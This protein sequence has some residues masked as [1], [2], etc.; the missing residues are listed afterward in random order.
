MRLLRIVLLALMW[1]APA[2]ARDT[3]V[4]EG[5]RL[6]KSQLSVGESRWKLTIRRNADGDSL[7]VEA[8]G[9]NWRMAHEIRRR[10]IVDARFVTGFLTTKDGAVAIL[11][12]KWDNQTCATSHIVIYMPLAYVDFVM[13]KDIETMVEICNSRFELR[14]HGQPTREIAFSSPGEGTAVHTVVIATNHLETYDSAGYQRWL[15]AE[16]RKASCMVSGPLSGLLQAITHYHMN[17][18]EL[19]GYIMTIP[20]TCFQLYYGE[21]GYKED[22]TRLY[23]FKDDE[24][25]AWLAKNVD[26][27][28]TINIKGPVWVPFNTWYPASA[29]AAARGYEPMSP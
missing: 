22:V 13:D 20:K 8:Q 17:G 2:Q 26:R 15:T 7:L 11:E 29:Q 1:V 28:V 18:T 4:A 6:G 16:R 9:R 12:V 24:T 25:A 3:D 23:L 5:D 27:R 14:P 21:M 10:P 19:H